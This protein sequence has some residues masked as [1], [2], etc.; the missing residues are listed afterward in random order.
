MSPRPQG[1]EA[2]APT[3]IQQP[4]L[5]RLVLTWPEGGQ[6]VEDVLPLL[7]VVVIENVEG[8]REQRRHEVGNL[9]VRQ[10]LVIC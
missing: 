6:D 5:Q 3:I 9:V 7:V 10:L 2:T 1:Y 8:D 4:C